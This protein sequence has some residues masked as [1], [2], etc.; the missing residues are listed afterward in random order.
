[1]INWIGTNLDMSSLYK[2]FYGTRWLTGKKLKEVNLHKRKTVKREK[3]IKDF[4]GTDDTVRKEYSRVA[5]R[6]KFSLRR[7]PNIETLVDITTAGHYIVGTS[8]SN[9]IV[10]KAAP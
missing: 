8:R 2:Q 4:T 1:M 5:P 7:D 3:V 6:T 9:S 10:V